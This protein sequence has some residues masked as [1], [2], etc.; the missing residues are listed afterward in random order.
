MEEK[1][2]VVRS[3]SNYSIYY[4]VSTWESYPDENSP[5]GQNTVSESVSVYV[6]QLDGQVLKGLY[7]PYTH[8][9]DYTLEE[10]IDGRQLIELTEKLLRE[11]KSKLEPFGLYDR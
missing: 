11:M 5:D 1:I 8:R 10:I 4:G 2:R 6:G 9:T 3:G 7:D